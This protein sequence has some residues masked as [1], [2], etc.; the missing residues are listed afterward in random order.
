MP[1]DR[2][3]HQLIEAIKN[4]NLARAKEVLMS[5]FERAELAVLDLGRTTLPSHI[6]DAKPFCYHL[7]KILN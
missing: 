6:A 2:V 4:E 7:F 3:H 5:H 1:A